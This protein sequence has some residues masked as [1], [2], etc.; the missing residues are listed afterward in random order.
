[1]QH[2][3]LDTAS[4]SLVSF[5]YQILK[6]INIVLIN[7]LINTFNFIHL[8]ILILL[9]KETYTQYSEHT[10]THTHTRLH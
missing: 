8:I 4:P 6:L 7:I 3:N 2:A 5:K 9:V 1:V 10:H